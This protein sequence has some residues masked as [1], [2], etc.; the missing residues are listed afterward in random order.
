MSLVDAVI[1][2]NGALGMTLALAL[3]DDASY[4]RIIVIGPRTRPG[5]ASLTAGAMINVWSELEAGALE[6]PVL[7]E[8]FSLPRKAMALWPD[9]AADLAERSGLEIPLHWGTWV[10]HSAR[11]P[12]A[13]DRSFAYLQRVL[14][15]ESIPHTRQAPADLP[16][17]AADPAL[18][19]LEALHVPDGRT[20]SRIV[21]DALELLLDRSPRVTLLDD[22]AVGLAVGSDGEKTVTLAGGQ[23]VRAPVVALANGAYAQALADQVPALTSSVPKLLFGGGSGLDL[24]FPD[25]CHRYESI[26]APLRDLDCVVRTMDR[27][28]ACGL[29]LIPHGG[30]TYFFGASSGVW[31]EPEPYPR[32]HALG[33][34][35]NGLKSEFNHAFFHALATVRG[36][37]F[38][39]VAM[40]TFPLVGE[41]EVPGVWY[42]NGTKRDGFTCA[43]HLATELAKAMAGRPADLPDRFRP[44]R[45]LI[46]YRNRA[47]A[48]RAAVDAAIGGEL[49]H[50]L[51]LPPYR[52]SEWAEQHRRRLEAVYERRGLEDF[53]IHPELTHLYESD[54]FFERFD[55][56]RAA[57][58]QTGAS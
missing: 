36:P 53:G 26:P 10:L 50:G 58:D 51:N 19:P 16:F 25:W 30:A 12:A 44:S 41:S 49:M 35:L 43:P 24:S 38:R 6:E 23:T 56:R 20:D 57:P 3:A 2:G 9:H 21:L 39:P 8:R 15:T 1:V 31:A 32:V 27:G 28:G 37:G 14:Q 18:R 42:L 47:Q 34:L 46:S 4:A 22:R 54:E 13:E 29:H 55:H 40:D 5:S 17:L 45:P 11:G 33:W 52:W 48:I 7:A